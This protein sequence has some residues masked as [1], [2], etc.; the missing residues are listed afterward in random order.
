MK[1]F[2]LERALAGDPV[3]TRDG[4]KVKI[5]GENAKAP[6]HSSVV[7][8]VEDP[9]GGYFAQ[10]WYST[11]TN[12]DYEGQDLFMAT[13]QY[14]GYINIYRSVVTGVPATGGTVYETEAAAREHAKE[15]NYITTLKIN[16]EE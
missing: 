11:G 3:V 13:K 2:N 1:Q 15:K 5:A 8:W 14:S 9:D 7:G 6:A 4:R 16:W 12:E 10:K